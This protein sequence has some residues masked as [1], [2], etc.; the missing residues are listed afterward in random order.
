MFI[1]SVTKYEQKLLSVPRELIR[2]RYTHLCIHLVTSSCCDDVQAATKS[3]SQRFVGDEIDGWLAMRWSGAVDEEHNWLRRT[4]SDCKCWSVE[5]DV[6]WFKHVD[7]IVDGYKEIDNWM[8]TTNEMIE[9]DESNSDRGSV[10]SVRT[11]E[12]MCSSA[13]SLVIAS[14]E[15]CAGPTDGGVQSWASKQRGKWDS[16]FERAATSW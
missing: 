5:G 1:T 3:T 16:K 15:H 4:K 6:S 11:R 14:T 12:N 13:S 2:W 10:A 7:S 9:V 8:T